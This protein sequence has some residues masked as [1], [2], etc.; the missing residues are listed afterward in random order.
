MSRSQQ[1]FEELRH[2]LWMLAVPLAFSCYSLFV[3]CQSNLN[4]MALQSALNESVQSELVEVDRQECDGMFRPEGASDSICG[5]AL[6][7]WI[8]ADS[9]SC[10][11][12]P[13]CYLSAEW[14]AR[15]QGQPLLV[16]PGLFMLVLV[17]LVMRK[18]SRARSVLK[19]ESS[20]PQSC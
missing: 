17:G 16:V 8:P 7:W 11:G 14:A 5:Y 2:S 10:E 20:S 15:E 13:P 19:S 9:S 4:E 12:G 18:I 3:V 6:E 1:A